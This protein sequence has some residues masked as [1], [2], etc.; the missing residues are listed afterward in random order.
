[1]KGIAH[2]SFNGGGLFLPA[3]NPYDREML[4]EH[5]TD[6]VRSK[7]QLRVRVDNVFWSVLPSNGSP[8]AACEGCGGSLHSLSCSI[9]DGQDYCAKCAFGSAAQTA[10]Q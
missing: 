7:G 9:A 5:V 2:I 3:R 4:V 1:M 8:E 10:Q 6:S